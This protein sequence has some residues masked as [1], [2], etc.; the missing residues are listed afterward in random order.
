MTIAVTLVMNLLSAPTSANIAVRQTN[1]NVATESA[2]LALKHV[3]AVTTA[4]MDLTRMSF[5]VVSIARLHFFSF[6]RKYSD[7]KNSR[8]N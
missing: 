3:T 8:K 2:L 5:T 7:W 1:F 6:L 4:M